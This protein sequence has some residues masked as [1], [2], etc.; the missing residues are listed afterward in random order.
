MFDKK[1]LS[2]FLVNNLFHLGFKEYEW[3]TL[4]INE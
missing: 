1:V 3:N 2:Q 4:H